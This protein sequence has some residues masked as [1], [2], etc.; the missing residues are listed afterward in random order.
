MRKFLLTACAALLGTL[1][2]AGQR[3]Y[4]PAQFQAQPYE[5]TA[6]TGAEDIRRPLNSN[7][8]LLERTETEIQIGNT[9]Y[10]LQ[11][12]NT[13][14]NRLISVPFGHKAGVFTFGKDATTGFPGR[15]TGFNSFDGGSWGPNP[16]ERLEDGVRTGWPAVGM[17][18][19]GSHVVVCHASPGNFLLLLRDGSGDWTQDTIPSNVAPGLL[20]PRMAVGGPDGN[21]LHVIAISTPV[22]NGGAAYEGIDG[23]L[24]YF[25]ST[26]GGN[27]WDITDGIIPGLD[28]T[29]Y[30]SMD[31]D[32]YAIDVSGN[33]VAIGLFNDL[34]DVTVAK[35]TDNGESWTSF[36]VKDFPIDQYEIDM[37]I[38]PAL[39]PP[40]DTVGAPPGAVQSSDSSGE[41]LID[42]DGR[43]HAW[44]GEMYYDDTDTTD[45][46]FLFFPLWNGIRY[47]NESFGEDS[48]RVIG[49]V[50]DANDNGVLDIPGIGSVG[51]YFTSLNSF[52]SA[53]VDAMNRLYVAYS[54][55]TEDFFNENATPELQHY[56]HIYVI[57]SEDGGET[58]TEPL[59]LIREDIVIEPTL[60]DFIEAVFP[61]VAREV[62]NQVHLIY[63]ADFE[64]GLSV[65]GDQDEAADN[66]INYIALDIEELGFT[67][68][69]TEEAVPAAAFQ[70]EVSPNPAR[71]PVRVDY[72]L[73][74]AGEVQISLSNLMGQTLLTQDLGT[75]TRGTHTAELATHT[76]PPGVYL[77]HLR[78]DNQI[79]TR[80]IV[81][82]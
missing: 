25:R 73:P 46:T 67:P 80:K 17:L 72:L 38:D 14:Q 60:I 12:N 43:V 39:I 75:Q 28:S 78:A 58:W 63:Q 69:A 19:D 76:L 77:L 54:A 62:D 6:L 27:T 3:L 36:V 79:A 10:D 57:G 56:R 74:Q 44:Y 64:P 45:G 59:D 2:L 52:F 55:I 70:L 11:T 16:T 71:G 15:G 9:W 13:M 21:T 49:G 61:A 22:A 29:K 51:A 47:W 18:A 81:L 35:S 41:V 20:W 4:A 24:L 31:A 32:G 23:H 48:T 34:G 7:L 33:T 53:G 26:D 82:Q 5:K 30:R 40:E 42:R 50:V 1:G 37:G 68:S 8:P 66:F 65:R